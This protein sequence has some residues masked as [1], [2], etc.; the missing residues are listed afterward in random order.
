MN[1]LRITTTLILLAAAVLVP[2]AARSA[3]ASTTLIGTV[4][5]GDAFIIRLTDE[6]GNAVTHLDPG[7]YTIRVHDASTLHNFHLTGP[8]VDQS[9]TEDFVGDV[10]WNVT[11]VDGTYEF[12]CDPHATRMHGSF[13]VGTVQT[14]P[15]PTAL[16]GVVGPKRTIALRGADGTRVSSLVTGRYRITVRDRTKA[17]NFRLRGPG[18]NK[19]TGIGFRGTARWTLT[20]APGSYTYRSDKH[21]SL[22]RS[23]RVTAS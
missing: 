22:R 19:A 23:F 9:T 7:A 15:P 21:K 20:L 10:T 14:P 12:H 18:V 11:F 3:P 13:T 2:G 16:S 17:D 5:V 6:S 4:G 8:G 1:P